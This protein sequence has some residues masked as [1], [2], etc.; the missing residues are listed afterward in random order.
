MT[1]LTEDPRRSARSRVLLTA[2]LECGGRTLPVVLRDLSEHGALIETDFFVE[3]DQEVLFRR[4]DLRVRGYV[5]W[6]HGDHA[7]IAFARQL[8]PDEVLQHIGRAA[9]RPVEEP[10]HR[11]PGVTRSGMS[12]EEQRWA[13]EMTRTPVR[14]GNRG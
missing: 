3:A 14:R 6:A 11:R 4:N 5:A 12:P 1:D 2:A 10:V 7:G 8:K 9:P 13:E